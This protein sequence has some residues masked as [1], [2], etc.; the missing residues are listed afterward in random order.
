MYLSVIYRERC[1][2]VNVGRLPSTAS[3]ALRLAF[4]SLARGIVASPLGRF[5]HVPVRASEPRLRAPRRPAPWSFASSA[6]TAEAMRLGPKKVSRQ[7]I[8]K[9]EMAVGSTWRLKGAAC[10]CCER[11]DKTFQVGQASLLWF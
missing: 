5:L 1:K 6:S 8:G 7:Q 4:S 11:Q 2:H 3:A 10:S 9:N